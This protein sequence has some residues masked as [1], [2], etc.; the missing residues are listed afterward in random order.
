MLEGKN[1]KTKKALIN[2]LRIV[3]AC[4]EVCVPVCVSP[5][6]CLY[7]YIQRSKLSFIASLHDR[8]ITT[9]SYVF[10]FK[11]NLVEVEVS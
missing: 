7:K 1:K 5:C 4:R 8:S 10:L 3:V 2:I 11:I 6:V 9:K